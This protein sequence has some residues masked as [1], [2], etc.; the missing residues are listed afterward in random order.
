MNNEVHIPTLTGLNIISL[1]DSLILKPL[2]YV[3]RLNQEGANAPTEEVTV[4]EIGM[5]GWQRFAQGFYGNIPTVP[6]VSSRTVVLGSNNFDIGGFMRSVT[7]YE[8]FGF[9]GI[10]TGTFTSVG[11]GSITRV[12]DDDILFNTV[13]QIEVF[14]Y[15]VALPPTVEDKFNAIITQIDTIQLAL[16]SKI[17]V[18]NNG[19]VTEVDGNIYR[20]TSN[21]AD[22]S[23]LINS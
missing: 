7:M 6:F 8:S 10:N 18:R 1:S 16:W 13:V 22:S 15:D 21:F 4:D 19:T 3:A 12:L 11:V 5:G 17:I 23:K 2:L 20:K 9:A 14:P